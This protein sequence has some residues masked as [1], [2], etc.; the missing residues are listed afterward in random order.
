[1]EYIPEK[2]A[3]FEVAKD[4]LIIHGGMYGR[5]IPLSDLILEKALSVNLHEVPDLKLKSRRNGLALPGLKT[6]WFRLQNKEKALAFLTDPNQVAYIPTRNGF[7]LLFSLQEPDR[8]IHLL[9]N[10]ENTA[11]SE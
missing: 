5:T 8:F 3:S 2:N 7:S 11:V 4:R 9:R 1:M 6:G 10:P